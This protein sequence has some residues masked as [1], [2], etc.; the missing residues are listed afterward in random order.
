[1]ARPVG[2]AAGRKVS[3]PPTGRAMASVRRSRS[4]NAPASV[5][6]LSRGVHTS[7]DGSPIR[8]GELA[9]ARPP[10]L[11][12]QRDAAV[13]PTAAWPG[14]VDEPSARQLRGGRRRRDGRSARRCRRSPRLARPRHRAE[15]GDRGGRARASSPGRI[16]LPSLDVWTPRLG[17]TIDAR[18]SVP[19]S[20]APDAGH[21]SPC[22]GCR[23]TQGGLRMVRR[24][25]GRCSG[26]NRSA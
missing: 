8:P 23:R 21:G 22:R 7:S 20:R 11:P 1:M 2:D 25:A 18:W 13:V 3:Q 6:Q 16:G 14:A 24:C 19:T 10:H 4:R 5:N 12:A 9:R 15:P 26:R 17:V